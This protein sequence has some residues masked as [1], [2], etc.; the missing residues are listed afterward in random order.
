MLKKIVTVVAS[1]IGL[2]AVGIGLAS[3]AYA[4]ADLNIWIENQSDKTVKVSVG[5]R[6]VGSEHGTTVMDRQDVPARTQFEKMRTPDNYDVELKFSTSIAVDVSVYT[7]DEYPLFE[8]PTFYIEDGG[9]S[10]SIDSP[11]DGVYVTKRDSGVWTDALM[12]SITQQMIDST[13]PNYE[14]YKRWHDGP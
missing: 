1:A 10:T 6:L 14:S 13:W 9:F 11:P 8:I 7:D 5:Y 12:I 2:L 4:E 3:P